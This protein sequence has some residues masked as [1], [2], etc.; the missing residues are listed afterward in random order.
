MDEGKTSSEGISLRFAVR[1]LSMARLLQMSK[2]I[3]FQRFWTTG[4]LGAWM[5]IVAGNAS[6]WC[7]SN[8]ASPP[9]WFCAAPSV[10]IT[11]P[12]NGAT[13]VFPVSISVTATVDNT[14]QPIT[15]VDFYVNNAFFQTVTTAPYSVTY[16]PPAAGTYAFKAIVTE[17]NHGTRTRTS[18]VVSVTVNPGSGSPPAVSITNPAN[19]TVFTAPVNITLT[20]TASDADGTVAKVDFYDGATLVGTATST[21]FSVT[22][23]SVA[24]G[25]H[26]LTARATDN[27]GLST[28]S[29][30]VTVL[31]NA[32]PA[33]GVGGTA[34]S[35]SV[36]HD[37]R[38][39]Y[40]VPIVASP[41]TAGMTP[42]IALTHSKKIENPLVGVGFFIDGL[43]I[44]RRC[45]RTIA[46][47]DVRGG[48]N[49]DSNDKFCLDGERLIALNSS[50]TYGANGVE[51]RTEHESFARI[52]SFR[53]AS[54]TGSG[55]QYFSVTTKDGTVM[56]FGVTDDSRIEA[57]GKAS[58]RLWA[59]NKIQDTRG[60]FYTVSYAEDSTNG[61]YRPLRVDY[62]GNSNTG[63]QPYNSIQFIYEP[64]PATDIRPRYEGGSLI[65]VTQRLKT[66]QAYADATLMREYRLTYDNA[67]TMGL[68]RLVSLTECAS[69]GT[70]F[71]ATSFTWNSSPALAFTETVNNN[72]MDTTGCGFNGGFFYGDW[73][74][75]G[76][77]DA[78]YYSRS[79]GGN[80][81]FINNG[82]LGFTKVTNPIPTSLLAC[83]SGVVACA[84]LRFGDWNGDGLIDVVWINTSSGTNRWFINIGNLNF[85]VTT[86]PIGLPANN[87]T[88]NFYV[89]DWN[90]D[91]LT[92]LLWYDWSSGTNLWFVARN[93]NGSLGF[94]QVTNPL[95]P[96]LGLRDGFPWFGDWNGDGVTD[97]MWIAPNGSGSSRWFVNDGNVAF[98]LAATNPI[99][100]AQFNGGG[101][102]DSIDFN[103]DGITDAL[104]LSSWFLNNGSLG[105]T[106]FSSPM[107]SSDCCYTFWRDWNSD[108]ITDVMWLDAR[109][110]GTNRWFLNN[111]NLGVTEITNPIAPSS[112]A[113]SQ[114][115]RGNPVFGDF[116]GDGFTDVLRVGNPFESTPIHWFMNND[117]RTDLLLAITNGLGAAINIEYKPLTDPSVH[118]PG[119]YSYPYQRVVNATM[120]VSRVTQSDGLGGTYGINYQ[121]VGAKSHVTGPG[122]LGFS[123][124]TSTDERTG[125]ATTTFL[126]QM[127]DGTA[128][129]VSTVLTQIN[130]AMLKIQD[131]FWSAVDIEGDGDLARGRKLARLDGTLEVTFELND[132][133]GNSITCTQVDNSFRPFTAAGDFGDYGNPSQVV[134]KID[135]RCNGITQLIKTTTNVY[136][137]SN[138]IL[139]KLA[140]R[141][142]QYDAP[143]Q[144]PIIRSSSFSYDLRGM[145]TQETIEPGQP[146]SSV[147]RLATNYTYDP[148]GNRITS[149]VSGAQPDGA[150]L[151][152]T[153]SV[154]YDSRG[155]FVVS[156]TNALHQTPPSPVTYDARWGVPLSV[157]DL[158]GLT[159]Y[160][161]YDVFGRKILETRADGSQTT[162]TYTWCD[163]STPCASMGNGLAPRYNIT[164]QATG[165]AP[166]KTYFDLINRAV[167]NEGL[168]LN[169]VAVYQDTQYDNRGRV[170]QKSHPY[171]ASDLARS[172]AIAYDVLDR[173]TVATNADGRVTTNSYNGLTTTVTGSGPG[174]ATRWRT[175]V[176][177][178]RGQNLSVVDSLYPT[179]STIYGYDAAGQITSVTDPM[180]N[181][182]AIGY[183]VRGRK[184]S[185]SDPDMGAWSYGYNSVSELKSQTD[186]KLQ[187]Q[188]VD[189]D[190]L[191]RMKKR[192]TP[193]GTST[194]T[195]DAAVKG[196]GKLAS[197]STTGP[198]G[199][200]ESHGYDN[201]SRPATTTITIDTETYTTGTTYDSVS[202]VD[203]LTYPQTGFVIRHVY[204]ARGYLTELRNAQTSALYWH[205]LDS[206]ARGHLTR[207]SLN[208][209]S[210]I[211]D[212]AYDPDK[213]TLNSIR[214]TGSAGLIQ[215][216]GYSFD[217]RGNL[218]SRTDNRQVLT[219]TFDY[220]TLN[221]LTAVHGVAPKT[222]TYDVLGNITFKSDVGTYAYGAKPHA[223]TGTSGVLNNTYAYDLNGN[224]TAGAGRTI[225]YTSF[226]K[227]S[228]ISAAGTATGFTYDPSFNRIKK[229][230]SNSTTIY[231]GSMYERVT[232]GAVVEHKHYVNGPSGPVALYTQ[233]SNNT[234]DTRYLRTDH[235]GSLDTI[236]DESSNAVL[237]LAFDAHGKRRNSNWTD[238]T[239][240]IQISEP[241]TMGFTGHE[242]D[243][244]SA[245]VNMNARQYDPMLGRF[246]TADTFVETSFG[247]GLNRYT[248]SRNSP[249]S[250]TDPTG[251]FSE[252]NSGVFDPDE[253]VGWFSAFTNWFSSLFSG[254]NAESS[255]GQDAAAS[256]QVSCGATYGIIASDKGINVGYYLNPPATTTTVPLSEFARRF[257]AD[258]F[259][260]TVATG[261]NVNNGANQLD[262]GQYSM[263]VAIK[264][265][266]LLGGFMDIL[267]DSRAMG[268]PNRYENTFQMGNPSQQAGG[269]AVEILLTLGL[270]PLRTEQRLAQ[271]L[272]KE[273]VSVFH[274][275]IRDGPEILKNGFDAARIPTFVSRDI[276]AAQDTL[277]NHPD[278]IRG[279]GMIIES[280]IPASEFQRQFAPFERSYS[281]FFPYG[282]QSTEIPLRTPLQIQ[283]FNEYI[284]R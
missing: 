107:G 99:D 178:V 184:T 271:T 156:T 200:A 122:W 225:S 30:A 105:F 23:G 123:S 89:G 55:P 27:V 281:G 100:P 185:T 187:T 157:T 95:D 215:D 60:N 173:V 277:L 192:F 19:N 5:V 231:V 163:V 8:E 136:D 278:A 154:V 244:E 209:E 20:A 69:D 164:T 140:S 96:S 12:A 189:Y 204:N 243:D 97:V 254:S 279:A 282:I 146:T 276:A 168:S 77:T 4:L 263:G 206:D 280:R 73:N 218:L 80:C 130:G 250:L 137:H 174:V 125:I 133:S 63:L 13:Y 121:Y 234:S 21:P 257:V 124:I 94:T 144:I 104:T 256:S 213:D 148:F 76:L 272:D 175:T 128:G 101:V 24:V 149:T 274:G 113:P 54:F 141:Q 166:A 83:T 202:R 259:E 33:G 25:T 78:M 228:Q 258:M 90:G 190:D 127:Y 153:N 32:L 28:T 58:V 129:R 93:N 216:L 47:D 62:T 9:V 11:S 46:L 43:S 65:K 212:R 115:Y 116:N 249:L 181:V 106:Q 44:I 158:N 1:L 269:A 266:R 188:S 6:A 208:N 118:T 39:A 2:S 3:C 74:G 239:S 235:L 87:Y 17:V 183:D 72:W 233:R 14:G 31:V 142:V 86:N 68:S 238:P 143:G 134:A 16:T 176:K 255:W 224:M 221:R 191:G 29:A 49:Y 246:I 152:R 268:V 198:T 172:D 112:L 84:E 160:I 275:S 179:Q 241:T 38:A 41:G 211:T 186:A 150:S 283:L 88:G 103:G 139:G 66:I 36:D 110:S 171:F 7:E 247:Q 196:I 79:S 131:Q 71:P 135:T 201:F 40:T 145:L 10:S 70:C 236:I 261:K 232:V 248:Y 182:T 37:G 48:V 245:L 159:T 223:V 222:F 57:Q 169:G 219:E 194:W 119:Y 75:D 197:I 102:S 252:H 155:R 229:A 85:T 220:D 92:D 214:T 91:G 210:V 165:N 64:K 138:G 205:A 42:K 34:G 253:S 180:G 242:M 111:G 50:D 199:Y 251:F 170:A 267:S 265:A 81:W 61:E 109:G 195:Y 51:Y 237:R 273:M 82:N 207:D 264:I 227:P 226:N 203:T 260:D 59:L 126:N 230:N 193:E 177:N 98:T 147:L 35:F 284:I 45:G 132:A 108:G 114:A 167:R 151:S 56:E 15:K 117:K 53:D 161:Q 162:I 270:A 26:T 67:G 262:L 22:L 240:P 120:V 18:S 217:V 52:V